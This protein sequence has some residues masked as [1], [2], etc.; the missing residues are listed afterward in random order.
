[1]T[2]IYGKRFEVEFHLRSLFIRCGT[3]ERFYTRKG[4]RVES[5]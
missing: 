5:H 4:C 3:F 2:I 1:M